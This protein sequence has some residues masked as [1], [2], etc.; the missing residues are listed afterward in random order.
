MTESRTPRPD[1][2]KS[3]EPIEF[4]VEG[5]R[6]RTLYL[7]RKPAARRGR[8][9]GARLVDGGGRRPEDYAAAIVEQAWRR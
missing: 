1:L 8:G 7:P 3:A 6:V 9:A 4:V 2:E 5:D